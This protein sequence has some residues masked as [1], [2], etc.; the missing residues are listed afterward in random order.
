[1]IL[2]LCQLIPS[3]LH[4]KEGKTPSQFR[5]L[6]LALT[7]VFINIPDT[8]IWKREFIFDICVQVIWVVIWQTIY[9]GINYWVILTDEKSKWI[10]WRIVK[11]QKVYR[12]EFFI[13]QAKHGG[14]KYHSN[15]TVSNINL[16]SF[17]Y[18]DNQVNALFIL[19]I[20][21]TWIV[22]KSVP[23]GRARLMP[24]TTVS[25]RSLSPISVHD[26]KWIRERSVQYLNQI[27]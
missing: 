9:I 6:F 13:L 4:P 19:T 1:M 5:C 2:W 15:G 22:T 18:N 23:E 10:Y 20:R 12:W 16:Y 11:A 8:Y 17:V 25:S 26:L 3:V 21:S 14:S 24:L 27:T 7:L